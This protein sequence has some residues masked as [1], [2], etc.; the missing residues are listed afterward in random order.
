[1][2]NKT[3]NDKC[4]CSKMNIFK[5]RIKQLE[6]ELRNLRNPRTHFKVNE[7]SYKGD[8]KSLKQAQIMCNMLNEQQ[9]N[10]I[11]N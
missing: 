1:M 10:G 2:D 11:D 6:E 8:E 7:E 5:T 4:D 3:E 9:Q